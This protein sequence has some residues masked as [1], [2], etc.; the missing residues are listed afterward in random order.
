MNLAN[1]QLEIK[2]EKAVRLLC[3]HVPFDP[4]RKKSILMH[5]LRVGMYLSEHNYS[6]EIVV[7]GLL[8]DL[9]EWTGASEDL[10][11]DECGEHV[12]EIIKAN[13]KNRDIEDVNERHKDYVNRCSSVGTDALIVKAADTLD[14]YHFYTAVNNPD[15]IERSKSIAKLI[16]EHTDNQDPIFK[17]LN[18]II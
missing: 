5:A 10:I 12:L 6:D 8:H 3:E 4:D 17:K 2:F 18:K 14:S 7:A 16:I 9:L 1:K 11:R 13:T 15:E